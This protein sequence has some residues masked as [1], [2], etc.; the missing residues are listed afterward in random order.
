MKELWRGKLG[1]KW[2]EALFLGYSRDS[3]EYLVWSIEEASK[4]SPLW[5]DGAV[6]S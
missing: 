1:S 6:R 2:K 3:N 5:D 4:E